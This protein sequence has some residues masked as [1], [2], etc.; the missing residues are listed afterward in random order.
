MFTFKFPLRKRNDHVAIFF[1]QVSHLREVIIMLIQLPPSLPPSLSIPRVPRQTVVQWVMVY[2]EI[3][4]HWDG[5]G[6]QVVVTNHFCSGCQ[7]DCTIDKVG[8]L[9][10]KKLSNVITGSL[11]PPKRTKKTSKKV[12]V[13]KSTFSVKWI[14][15]NSSDIVNC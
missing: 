14:L 6:D 12:Q 15:V 7:S 8:V 4:H 3:F 10:V 2:E 1:K 5:G 13:F 9:K 11:K